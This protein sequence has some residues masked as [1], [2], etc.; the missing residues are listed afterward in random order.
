M[1]RARIQ[2]SRLASDSAVQIS[3]SLLDVAT[4]SFLILLLVAGS[5][6]NGL[7]L[8]S[9]LE[10]VHAKAS[11]MLHFEFMSSMFSR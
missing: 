11:E 9:R 1:L 5:P 7:I 2:P 6:N 4:L 8:G 10:L 3:S